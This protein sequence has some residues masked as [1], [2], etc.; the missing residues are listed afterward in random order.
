MKL[1]IS[2][3][4]EGVACVSDR[5]EVNKATAAEYQPARAQ[6]T[7]E[8]AAACEGG[9][10]A[11]AGE[12]V[13]KDAHWTGRNLDAHRLA[14]PEG[15]SLRL[16]RGWSGHPFSMV[17]ELDAS[18]DALA[19]V[20][21]H[22]PAGRGGNPLA[23][24]ISSRLFARLELNGVVASEFLIFSYA[25]ALVDVPVAFLAGDRALCDDATAV[26][27]GIVTVPTLEGRGPSIVSLTPAESVRQI[28]DGVQRAVAGKVG[29]VLPLPKEF[30]IR[31][32]FTSGAEAFRRSF[33]PGAILASDTDVTFETRDYFEVLRLLAFMTL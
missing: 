9:F 17:Q 22:S 26:V 5:D 2:A 13:V 21:Y 14:A 6:M 18:F 23:H 16:V 27:D 11:G 15:R 10:A 4:M 3:D 31:I 7:A 1:F 20:G 19:F 32:T 8:V 24:T 29:C 28:R 25:A 12:I 30:H 33:Y